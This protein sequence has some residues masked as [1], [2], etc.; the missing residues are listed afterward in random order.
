MKRILITGKNSYV[1]NS[2]EKWLMK[3]PENYKVDKISLRNDDWKSKDFSQYDSV[4]HVAAIVHKKERAE[5]K[6]LYFRINREVTI[7]IAK[8]A[9]KAGVSQF[10]FMSTMAVYGKVGKIG[11][12]LVINRKTP[13]NPKTFYGIS[14]LGAEASLKKLNDD[15]FKIVIL[16]PPMVYGP[17]SPGNYAR[18]E[19]IA[20][21]LPIF[22][23]INNQRSMIHIDK[24]CQY[25][26]NHIDEEA[27]GLYLPQDDN[28]INTSLL[29]KKIAEKN[30]KSIYLS[31]T[32]GF[33]IQI[34]CKKITSVNKVF[35]NLTYKKNEEKL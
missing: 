30:G 18:L 12:S 9:K 22:P 17:K 3:E 29:V 33:A 26:K 14:K 32:L 7:E 34:F 27:T 13:T 28:Y 20:I 24:L 15:K 25:V 11:K 35:G 10:I 31:K 6:E 16:R 21:K 4:L 2:V 8:K 5:L 1:G 23:M 19:K